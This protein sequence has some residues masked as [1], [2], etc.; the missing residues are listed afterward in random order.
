MDS[1][2]KV[3]P[4]EFVHARLYE[5]EAVAKAAAG[6]DWFLDSSED[7][8]ERSIRYTG[9]STLY[10][11]QSADYSIA[12]R[13]DEDDAEHI[14]R[15][16]PAR[17]LREITAKR[18]ILAMAEGQPTHDLAEETAKDALEDVVRVLA[19]AWSDHPDYDPDWMP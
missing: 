14:A 18:A 16:D 4:I 7:Y 13:V 11:G 8:D 10:R 3:S 15:H 19:V 1:T 12:D 17:V 2:Q 6:P 9:P 5:D